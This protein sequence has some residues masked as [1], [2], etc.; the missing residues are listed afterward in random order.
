MAGL[1]IHIPFCKSRCIYC[2]F[3]STTRLAVREAYVDALACE[4]DEA[5]TSH[6]LPDE[7]RTVSTVYLGGGTPSMLP[8]RLL[9]RLFDHIGHFFT[10]A[11]GAEITLEANPDDL[12]PQYVA[13]LRRLP[14]NRL[15][16]GVQTFDDQRL[17]FL[18]R[19][20]TAA[21]AIDAVYRCQ[22]AGLDNLSIDL[23]FGFPGQTPETWSQDVG[24][25]IRLRPAHLSAYSLSYEPG[26]RLTRMLRE[27]QVAEIDEQAASD[28]YQLLLDLTARAGFDHYEISNFCLPDRHSRHNSSYWDGTP[29]WGLGAGAHSFDG[30][31]RSWNAAHL[32]TYIK[33]TR[34]RAKDVYRQ[35]ETLTTAER[36]NE[37][38]MTRL[39][40]RQGL[41][42]D[43]LAA[44]FGQSW[45]DHC[46]AMSRRH[47]QAGTL[48]LDPHNHFLRLTRQ[49]IFISND[50]M[51]DLFAD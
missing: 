38:I 27:G 44:D 21:Q 3:F 41:D 43:R 5:T 51:A 29:Y 7:A 19:R 45:L 25:A 4:M 26:T 47:L 34:A 9:A 48:Q 35:S 37:R 20:H 36:Y 24:Q 11:D 12:T 6:R 49:G 22:D 17:R 13:G 46:L 30:L 10:I 15:S 50:I 8:T 18:Q 16:M 28:M 33:G 40:T 1:Y 14:V 39:R 2:D 32:A 42:L 23:M 31:Q